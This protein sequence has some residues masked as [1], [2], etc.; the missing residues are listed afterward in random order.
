MIKNRLENVKIAR[1]EY[2]NVLDFISEEASV[3]ELKDL[4]KWLGYRDKHVRDT[5]L[6]YF[7]G[8]ELLDKALAYNC[9]DAEDLD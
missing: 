7:N 4:I 6:K 2:R 8:T 9:E 5:V 3:E 1:E